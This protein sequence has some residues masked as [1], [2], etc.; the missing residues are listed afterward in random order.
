MQFESLTPPKNWTPAFRLSMVGAHFR[1]FRY[2]HLKTQDGGSLS[3]AN[4]C[5]TR[6]NWTR[7]GPH[8]KDLYGKADPGSGCRMR[9]SLITGGPALGVGSISFGRHAIS[10]VAT[11]LR[12]TPTSSSYFPI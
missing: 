5:S 1:D 9:S 7:R 3:G 10:A 4:R 8:L 2:R 11:A 6:V 12:L